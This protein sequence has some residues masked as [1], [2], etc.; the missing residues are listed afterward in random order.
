MPRPAD[1]ATTIPVPKA[2]P[3]PARLRCRLAQSASDLE[4]A[5]ALRR[6]AFRLAREDGDDHDARCRHVL[7]EERATGAAVCTCRARVIAPRDAH[8]SYS[9]QFYDLTRL[10]RYPAPLLELG[11]FALHPGWRDPQ[12]PRMAWAAVTAMVDAAGV[13]FLF[14]CSSFPGTDP[15]PHRAALATLADGFL[16]PARWAPGVK[17]AETVALEPD[18][19]GGAPPAAGLPPLLRSY[20][21]MGGRVSDHAVIDRQMNTL[22]VFTGIEVARI[23]PARAQALRRLAASFD[24]S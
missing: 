20:L 13:G 17:A 8:T 7:V 11:R 1:D 19:Q 2:D 15:A 9:A 5:R 4:A 23:P 6:L 21:A 14:G 24:I 10:R 3:T 16:A 12:I 18:G 22:H